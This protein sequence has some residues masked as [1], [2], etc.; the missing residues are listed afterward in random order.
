MQNTATSQAN[1]ASNSSDS[2]EKL[3]YILPDEIAREVIAA[4]IQLYLGP[5]AS[6]ME[7]E[8]YTWTCGHLVS[9]EKT[10]TERMKQ[11]MV[12]DSQRWQQEQE[13][14]QRLIP[15]EKSRT[16]ADRVCHGPTQ[17]TAQ[18]SSASA[19]TAAATAV[20]TA[21]AM[22]AEWVCTK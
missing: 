11:D 7:E 10:F 22:I 21:A 8:T 19:A 20:A 17:T 16:H 3:W 15:Y 18:D 1:M 5:S 4:D 9:T 14:E 6:V 2:Q 12:L 13:D